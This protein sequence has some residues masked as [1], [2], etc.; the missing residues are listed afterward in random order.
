MRQAVE[1]IERLPYSTTE[2]HISAWGLVGL[3]GAFICGMMM[4]RGQKV[5]WWWLLGVVTS[6]VLIF[7]YEVYAYI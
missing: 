6:I 1:W 4:I 7:K 3:Y 5:H 2:I